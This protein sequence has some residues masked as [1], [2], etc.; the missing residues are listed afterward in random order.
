[1]ETSHVDGQKLLSQKSAV[2]RFLDKIYVDNFDGET[3][4]NLQLLRI[5]V[6]LLTP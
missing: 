4:W 3:S 5:I 1:M 2:S 6:V